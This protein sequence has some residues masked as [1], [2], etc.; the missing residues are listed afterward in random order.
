DLIVEPIPGT[1]YSKSGAKVAEHG[2]FAADDT[3]A[4]L[5]VAD[6]GA[7]QGNGPS[8]PAP[9]RNPHTSQVIGAAVT[10]AQVA[11]PI[12]AALGLEPEPLEGVKIEHPQVLPGL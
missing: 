6:G 10:T 1:I 5:I 2:G 12:L 9:P 11:P 4:A 8:Q 3:H 7:L